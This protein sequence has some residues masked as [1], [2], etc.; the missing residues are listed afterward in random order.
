MDNQSFMAINL[1]QAYQKFLAVL[2]KNNYL[3]DDE[4]VKPKKSGNDHEYLLIGND[5][6]LV[7][8]TAL[9]CVLLAGLS[10]STSCGKKAFSFEDDQTTKVLIGWSLRQGL[11]DIEWSMLQGTTNEG[12]GFFLISRSDS[13]L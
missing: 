4:N 2:K 12:E 6:A 11:L 7:T 5:K 9:N 8:S 1:K 10:D 13:A 3:S